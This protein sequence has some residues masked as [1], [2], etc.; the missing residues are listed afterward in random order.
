MFFQNE[1]NLRKLG[2]SRKAVVK[3]TEGR[4]ESQK[5]DLITGKIQSPYSEYASIRKCSCTSR[6]QGWRSPLARLSSISPYSHGCSSTN[7]R[8]KR[9]P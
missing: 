7:S 6:I 8:Q 5:V 1:G 4:S 9:Y 3:L 2:N